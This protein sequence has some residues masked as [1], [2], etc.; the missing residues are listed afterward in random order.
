MILAKRTGIALSVG[1]AVG[2]LI[3]L[4][5]HEAYPEEVAKASKLLEEAAA[6]A[7]DPG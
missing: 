3:V 2:K 7:E 5:F 4:S 6:L 1:D